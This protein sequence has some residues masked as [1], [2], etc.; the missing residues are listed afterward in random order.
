MAV[1]TCMIPLAY[2]FNPALCLTL[3]VSLWLATLTHHVPSYYRAFE[4]AVPIPS[5][6][7]SIPPLVNSDLSSIVTTSGNLFWK[8]PD[9][10]K[11]QSVGSNSTQSF[12]FFVLLAK[13]LFYTCWYGHLA[14]IC[15][16]HEIM[17]LVTAGARSS[18]VL[19]CTPSIQNSVRHIVV[20][21]TF[22]QINEY[23]K[24]YLTRVRI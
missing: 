10:V 20:F 5:N 13:F 21:H 8:L 1:K 12:S 2:L 19:R 4:L 9:Q 23:F 14:N 22:L 11:S 6:V 24:F 7:L 16:L 18:C 3:P 15:F 17:N